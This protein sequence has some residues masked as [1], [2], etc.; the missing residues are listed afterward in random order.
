MSELY[1]AGGRTCKRIFR[2]P[3]LTAERFVA[4]PYGKPGQRMYRTGDLVKWRSDGVLE[5][6]NRADH[7]IKIRGFRI[8][9]AEIEMVLQRHENI[10]KQWLWYEKIVQM[11]NESL[12]ILLP[13][14]RKRFIFQKSRS[15]VSESL[16]N[17]MVPSAFVLLEE[18]PLTP[19]GKIDRKKLPAPDFN[20]MNNE[21][22]AR[23]PKEEI[24]CHLFA[25]VLGVSRISIDDN[26]FEMV[27]IRFLHRV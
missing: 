21:R 6:M 8:E 16:A 7:Q 3:E 25:E 22:V 20:G 19:N 4:N 13:K 9:L 18:L 23:N 11:I 15:Y 27:D 12:R 1:I 24:L 26:F 14:R 2:K 10:S 17:Y 5:Y